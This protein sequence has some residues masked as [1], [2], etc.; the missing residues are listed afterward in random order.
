MVVLPRA[1]REHMEAYKKRAGGLENWKRF[2]ISRVPR[3]LRTSRVQADQKNS[4]RSLLREELANT[5]THS[6]LL[7]SLLMGLTSK[8]RGRDSQIL[9][10]GGR[11]FS[12]YFPFPYF[13]QS[14]TPYLARDGKLQLSRSS[15]PTFVYIYISLIFRRA[16]SLFFGVV[17]RAED[18]SEVLV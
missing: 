10:R 11:S 14:C 17:R 8:L 12:P 6:D 4:D 2:Q 5:F 15:R 7:Q 16:V 3:A 18:R 13:P 1:R 9:L